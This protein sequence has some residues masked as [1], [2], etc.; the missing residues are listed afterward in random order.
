M[1]SHEPHPAAQEPPHDPE[2]TATQPT[3]R[4]EQTFAQL[5]QEFVHMSL[6]LELQPEHPEQPAQALI[7]ALEHEVQSVPHPEQG[8][9][10]AEPVHCPAQD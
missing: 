4:L 5:L 6:Q 2:H 3:H 10:F 8:F 1:L 9:A 7:H